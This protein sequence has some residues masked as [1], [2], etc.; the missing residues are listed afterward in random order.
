MRHLSKHKNCTISENFPVKSSLP[1]PTL[2]ET[3]VGSSL[4]RPNGSAAYDPISENIVNTISFKELKKQNITNEQ[5]LQW[6]ASIDLV[7]KYEMNLNDSHLF[8]NC[9]SPWF[10]SQCQYKLDYDQSLSFGE[11]RVSKEL[12]QTFSRQL[13]RSSGRFIIKII[14]LTKRR[15]YH[16]RFRSCSR[17]SSGGLRHFNSI[18]ESN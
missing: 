13:R 9:S 14:I 10:G 15:A 4:P 18:I 8:S 11:M 5:L 2:L 12:L 1:R 6:F 7:E 17:N 3:R 16:D